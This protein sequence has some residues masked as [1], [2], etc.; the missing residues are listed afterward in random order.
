MDRTDGRL[1]ARR[2]DV[3]PKAP[4]MGLTAQDFEGI[5]QLHARWAHSLDFGDADAFVACFA[6]DGVFDAPNG[7]YQGD[8]ELRRHVAEH[9]ESM[10]GHVRHSIVVSSM[11]DGDGAV[12]RSLSYGCSTR[13]YGP[14]A[15]KGQVTRSILLVSGIYADD[16]VKQDG[17]W[18]YARR[19]YRRDGTPDVLERFGKPLEIDPVDAGTSGPSMSAV[20]YEA[21]RQLMSRY[22]YTLDMSDED[23][24]LTCFTPDGYF[25]LLTLGDPD[26]GGQAR[27]Q[28]H[29]N[30]RQMVK[31]LGPRVMGHVRHGAST[32]LIEGDGTRAQVS[33]Y[34][35]FT[36][37]HGTPPRPTE[38]DNFMMETTGIYRDEVVKVDGRWLISQRT[39]RYDGWPDVL[40]RVGRPIELGLFSFDDEGGHRAAGTP[41]RVPNVVLGDDDEA[42]GSLTDLDYEAIR[43]LLALYTQTLDFADTDGFVGCF[44]PD[45][46]LDTSYPEPG[47]SGA[48]RGHD[49]L[50][51]FVSAANEHNAGRVRHAAVCP[52]IEG[53]GSSARASSYAVVTRD[54]GPPIAPGDLTHSELV[55]TGMFFDELIKLDGRWVFAR[56][57][58]RHDGLPEVLE[59]VGKP[60]T[61]GPVRQ[62]A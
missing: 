12:A 28:G 46:T 45:G 57:E 41:A 31:D 14:P 50:R 32:T 3:Y 52:L 16:L 24:F 60:V 17:R 6:S 30:L 62:T 21:I 29:E 58:F 34:A 5:K 15:G 18:L 42:T 1:L 55:T 8:E 27:I 2:L 48:H 35:F 39:F 7:S 49:E 51:E 53:D 54:F 36:S 61:V 23:G 13:D 47:L 4:A 11:I 40:E 22:A 56:R 59:R 26:F 9:L 10:L 25:E 33:T 43:E 38:P 44:A 19:R 37:D 20:D